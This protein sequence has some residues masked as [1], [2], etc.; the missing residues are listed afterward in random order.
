MKIHG[1]DLDEV[2]TRRVQ[3]GIF[4]AV[5]GASTNLADCDFLFA[6]AKKKPLA[7]TAASFWMM[8]KSTG[9]VRIRTSFARRAHSIP[10]CRCWRLE[11]ARKNIAQSSS[12][13]ARI[14]SARAHRGEALA[15]FLWV[16]GA[17][18]G[19]GT[20]RHRDV[21]GRGVGIDSQ[22]HV[23]RRRVREP[24][25][26]SSFRNVGESSTARSEIDCGVE[27]TAKIPGAQV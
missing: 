14:R 2:F 22:P 10:N 4:E 11:M 13:T 21:S 3:A 12:I 17:G 18:P 5:Q 9:L 16:G 15:E 25:Q 1:Y 27:T 19:G 8:D 24:H 6:L 26:E 20:R 23:A 7:K